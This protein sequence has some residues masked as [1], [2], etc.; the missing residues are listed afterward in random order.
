MTVPSHTLGLLPQE[1]ASAAG[2]E[3]GAEVGG[4]TAPCAVCGER[5]GSARAPG[6]VTPVY[7]LASLHLST[8]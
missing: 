5:F 6:L 3:V 2:G 7:T 8:P 1:E 4:E